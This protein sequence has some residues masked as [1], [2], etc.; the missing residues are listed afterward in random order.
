MIRRRRA[1]GLRN[2]RRSSR[3][4]LHPMALPRQGIE[5]IQPRLQVRWLAPLHQRRNTRQDRRMPLAQSRVMGGRFTRPRRSL[6]ITSPRLRRLHSI[7]NSR[8]LFPWQR[9]KRFQP[10]GRQRLPRR[11]P[12]RPQPPKR[13][14]LRKGRTRVTTRKS[15]SEGTGIAAKG[16]KD[17]KESVCLD[18]VIP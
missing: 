15:G 9:R 10:V 5:V 2:G 16:H 13:Q 7:R 6:P 1:N 17:R 8:S 18:E 4:G 12:P 14:R 3:R 11:F